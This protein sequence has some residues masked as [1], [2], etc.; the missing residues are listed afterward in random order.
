M[1][2]GNYFT[3]DG[4]RFLTELRS[5]N[6]KKWFDANKNRFEEGLKEP[7][8]R[9][10]ADFG[11]VLKGI[12]KHFVAD[13]KP[14][15]GSM[16]RIYRDT[17]FSKDKS[18]YKTALFMHFGHRK[19]TM[20]AMPGFYFHIEPGHSAAGGGVWHPATPALERIRKSI[21][22]SPDAWERAKG[23]SLVGSACSMGGESLKKVPRGYDP[24][25]RFAEDLKRK[26]FGV[27]QPLD[28]KALSGASL[29][30]DLEKSFR[31]A[32]PVIEF[33]CKAVGLPF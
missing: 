13:P 24:D 27:S 7:G 12:S 14:N 21:D 5:H 25:H 15:G 26:D 32:A 28:D 29:L 3:A 30:R 1:T 10:I 11:T 2:N 22:K 6:E 17:R 33:L 16:S 9:L 23:A 20:D 4:L 18:P 19:G 8:L 31:T